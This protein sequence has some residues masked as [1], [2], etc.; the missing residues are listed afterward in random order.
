L[1]SLKANGIERKKF[2]FHRY[3][4]RALK[5][6]NLSQ[7]GGEHRIAKGNFLNIFAFGTTLTTFSSFKSWCGQFPRSMSLKASIGPEK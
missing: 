4:L 5:N 7:L 3:K 1:R 6:C 2:N